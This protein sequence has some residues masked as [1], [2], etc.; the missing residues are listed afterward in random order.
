M[1]ISLSLPLLKKLR[2]SDRPNKTASVKRPLQH[3]LTTYFTPAG[4]EAGSLPF[5]SGKPVEVAY[6][7]LADAFGTSVVKFVYVQQAGIVYYIGCPAKGFISAPI[8]DT[9]TELAWAL[10][11]FVAN[12]EV[13]VITRSSFDQFAAIVRKGTDLLVFSG[14]FE[15]ASQFIESHAPGVKPLA[16]P[17]EGSDEAER[18]PRWIGFDQSKTTET[19]RLGAAAIVVLYGWALLMSAIWVGSSYVSGRNTSSMV[20]FRDRANSAIHD[21]ANTLTSVRGNKQNAMILD[22]FDR[23]VAIALK[24][25]GK[26]KLLRFLAVDGQVKTWEIEIPE[27]VPPKAYESLQADHVA[28]ID[29]KLLISKG[30]PK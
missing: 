23:L 24:Q 30:L 22:E 6:Q 12:D 2:T 26:G 8:G 16:T 5:G 13:A 21:A 20:T 10:P 17:A 4:I 19:Q 7:A 11:G 27:Y 9:T 25:E 3:E 15:D 1:R 28:R 29:G 14:S 18:L